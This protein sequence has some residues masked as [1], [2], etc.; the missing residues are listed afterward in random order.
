MVTRAATVDD[1][2]A[3]L[4]SSVTFTADPEDD[5]WFRGVSDA[6]V[7][8]VRLGDFPEEHLY[9]LYLGHGRWMDF[10]AVPPNWSL[11]STGDWPPTARPRLPKG[12]FYP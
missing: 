10:T 3:A 1:L 12:H 4:S 7:L 2:E 5:C 11:E 9:S 8:Y 6:G